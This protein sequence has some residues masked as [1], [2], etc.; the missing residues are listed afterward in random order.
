MSFGSTT[1]TFI[2]LLESVEGWVLTA[3]TPLFGTDLV[4]TLCVLLLSKLPP[5]KDTLRAESEVLWPF[6]SSIWIS[7]LSLYERF[8]PDLQGN[9]DWFYF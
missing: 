5:W 7:F 3:N 2:F 9:S 4:N 1:V 8:G 6:D